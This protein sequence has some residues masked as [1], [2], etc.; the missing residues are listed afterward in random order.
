[1]L[2]Q[3]TAD[4]DVFQQ[5]SVSSEHLLSDEVRERAGDG[6]GRQSAECRRGTG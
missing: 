5:R 4:R 2:R 6:E 1:M 3:T